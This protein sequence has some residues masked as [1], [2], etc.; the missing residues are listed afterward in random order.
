[1]ADDPLPPLTVQDVAERL[2]CHPRT[3]WRLEGQGKIPEA[4]RVTR[5]PFWDRDEFEAWY[6]TAGRN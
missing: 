4:R 3:I 2:N 6:A 5:I 1:M